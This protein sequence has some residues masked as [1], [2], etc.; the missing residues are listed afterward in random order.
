MM[1]SDRSMNLTVA[2]MV[3]SCFA[4]A[5]P[6][7]GETAAAHAV[8]E[9]TITEYLHSMREVPL[10]DV[11]T[12]LFVGE[13]ETIRTLETNP[14][15]DGKFVAVV[16]DWGTEESLQAEAIVYSTA[17]GNQLTSIATTA[18]DG[19]TAVGPM[20]AA[21]SPDSRRLFLLMGQRDRE[22]GEWLEF[23]LSA[24]TFR[25]DSARRVTALQA[26]EIKDRPEEI[27]KDMD[28]PNPPPQW[29]LSGRELGAVRSLV[30]LENILNLGLLRAP[31]LPR[32]R[33]VISNDPQ[34]YCRVLID[35]DPMTEAKP[36]RFSG[37]VISGNTPIATLHMAKPYVS[38]AYMLCYE[39]DV[40]VAYRI[41]G[42]AEPRWRWKVRFAGMNL[43]EMDV[44]NYNGDVLLRLTDDK[45]VYLAVLRSGIPT[46]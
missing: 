32:F 5:M 4:C 34:A 36:L 29:D 2:L 12:V 8:T 21:W 18:G 30:P 7:E 24:G 16:V 46:Y 17:D 25:E 20:G 22:Y 27:L 9:T 6:V 31:T 38:E 33:W 14:S 40:L 23:D 10:S 42:P 43:G 44:L 15:F 13:R 35:C 37:W 45:K 3:S 28:H 19:L 26:I 41:S 11:G 39:D 1:I